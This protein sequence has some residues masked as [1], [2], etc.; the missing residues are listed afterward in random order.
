MR[1]R[2]FCMRAVSVQNQVLADAKVSQSRTVEVGSKTSVSFSSCGQTDQ[3]YNLIDD[4]PNTLWY[5]TEEYQEDPMKAWAMIE[6]KPKKIKGYRIQG[7]PS[8]SGSYPTDWVIEGSND[9][10]ISVQK[11]ENIMVKSPGIF[12]IHRIT[13]YKTSGGST[14]RLATFQTIS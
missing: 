7:T 11:A 14:V 1:F 2:L 12:K 8:D 13:I 6:S 9:G 3:A 10:K 5:A 4:N